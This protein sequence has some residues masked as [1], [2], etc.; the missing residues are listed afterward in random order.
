MAITFISVSYVAVSDKKTI[1]YNT[2]AL[3]TTLKRFIV[4]AK[5]FW[6][7]A[8]LPTTTST[9]AVS[10]TFKEMCHFVNPEKVFV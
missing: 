8:V 2:A 7:D 9:S 6:C 3:I 10:S 4:Q 5:R 1:H